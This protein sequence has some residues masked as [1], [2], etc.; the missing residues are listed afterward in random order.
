MKKFT[1]GVA[2]ILLPLFVVIP[3]TSC[4]KETVATNTVLND[5]TATAANHSLVTRAYRDSF[6]TYFMFVPD[7]AN[8]WAPPNPAPAW[9]PGGGKGNASHFGKANS[10][11]NQYATLGPNGLASTSAPVTMFFASALSSA[12]YSNIPASVSTIVYDDKGNSVWFSQGGSSTTIPASPTRVNF[13]GT[14]NIIGG[15][16][17]FAGATGQVTLN[18]YFNPQ[19]P[20]DASFWQNGWIKY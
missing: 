9:Y 1:I 15:T 20:Q 8:G 13:F 2:A 3:F 19:D 7:F 14:N 11:F 17:K 16:G 6:D 18:G 10:F 12:G 4:Q 5:E